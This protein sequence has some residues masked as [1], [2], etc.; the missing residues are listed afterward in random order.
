MTILRGESGDQ[1]RQAR[2]TPASGAC[3]SSVRHRGSQR[4]P[5]RRRPPAPGRKPIVGRAARRCRSAATATGGVL[6]PPPSEMARPSA[7]PSRSAPPRPLPSP[8]PSRRSTRAASPMP[9]PRSRTS[10]IRCSS[11]IV[12]WSMLRVGAQDRRR[13]R[14]DLALPARES[15]LARAR[16]AA[17]PGRG[18][19][20]PRHAAGRGRR[21]TSPP[22]RRSPAPAT[23]AASRRPRRRARATCR[24]WRAT[25][26]AT[27]PSSRPT[28]RSSSTS[29]AS[30]LTA[31][32][33]DRPLRPHPARGPPAG[34]ARPA[35]QAAAGLPAARQCAAGHGDASRRCADRAA[36]RVAG[37]ARR[38]G[39]QARAR[40]VAAPHRQPRRR[41][42]AADRAQ[43]PTRPTPGGTS[44]SS[45]R[46][47]CW[48]PATPPTP[49]PSPCS[50]ARPRASPS[51]R[52]SSSPAG[53]RSAISR[54]RPTA[55]KHFQTLYDGVSTDISKSRAAYWMGRA[56]E[57]AG[58]AKEANEWYG[59]AAGFGQTFYGQLAARK[60]P[61]G[62]A[63]LPSDPVASPTPTGRR[64]AAAS[65]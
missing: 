19:H 40:A 17:P 54:S 48:R 25:A 62:A 46:A 36:R 56:L 9:A 6:P 65:W 28:R 58:R 3:P 21:A 15:R 39:D 41:Q 52:P 5:P 29:T 57:A 2:P 38:A 63:R 10:T 23:C 49:M 51:P 37:Q 61:G 42:G 60:L 31:R 7:R 22:S 18:P 20:R 16:G 44:A 12:D 34:G 1:P 50:T 64:W 11:R 35:V 8:P 45:S 53:S 27:P 55:Q 59:R 13:L 43:P 24:S 26:G 33:P 4:R 32:R 30:Y 14:L 47:I